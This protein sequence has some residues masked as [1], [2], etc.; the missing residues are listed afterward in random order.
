VVIAASRGIAAIPHLDR[1][2]AEEPRAV[3]GWGR[4]RSGRRAER[5]ARWLRRPC[6]LLED[7]FIRSVA[8]DDP[9]LSLI[10]DHRGGIYYDATAPSELEAVI[11]AG[12]DAD[13]AQRAHVLIQAWRAGGISK[14]NHADD[15]SGPLP[16][17]YVLVVDQT[18]GDRSVAL[19]LADA[20]SFRIMLDAALDENPGA[21]VVVKVHPDVFTR[22]RRGWLDLAGPQRERVTVIGSDCHAAGLIAGAQAVYAVTS[23]MGFEALLWDK[24]VRCFG[25]PFY[26]GWGLTEDEL[27]PPFQRRPVPLEALVHAALVGCSRYVDP[28]SGARWRA[29][30]AI[31]HVAA[32]RRRIASDAASRK[33][34]DAVLA[35]AA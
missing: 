25:M 9:P 24:P 14:Y 3:A 22:G 2:L 27:P 12:V 21:E 11:A 34:A 19:G 32:A 1:F 7:G 18:F 33:P 4:K 31:A 26:A 28:A 5:V 29:E 16:P 8:R 6:L 30:D 10:V 20:A 13:Q 17:R 35:G 23:L 15:H